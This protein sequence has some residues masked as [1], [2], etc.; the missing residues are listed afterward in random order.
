MDRTRIGG[1]HTAVKTIC[2]HVGRQARGMAFECFRSSD[3]DS[4]KRVNVDHFGSHY[5]KIKS[6][7]R[8]VKL[9]LTRYRVL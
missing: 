6:C 2:T 5:I 1:G 9:L 4:R 8:Q 7:T 3:H